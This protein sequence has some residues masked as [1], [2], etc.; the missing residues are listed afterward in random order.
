MALASVLIS[1]CI[2]AKAHHI[3]VELW[4]CSSVVCPCKRVRDPRWRRPCASPFHH[5]SLGHLPGIG[6]H[7]KFA[8]PKRTRALSAL[9]L[10]TQSAVKTWLR[11]LH[12]GF[13][14]GAASLT[15]EKLTFTRA[16]FPLTRIRIS[17]ASS[18]F[19]PAA[20]GEQLHIAER[21]L[22]SLATPRSW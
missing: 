11:A 22:D 21:P 3:D 17:L 12:G 8:Q 14:N 19:F 15:L 4:W 7:P 2:Y 16:S 20:L 13:D 10:T 6:T 1:I 18:G 5:R 9:H